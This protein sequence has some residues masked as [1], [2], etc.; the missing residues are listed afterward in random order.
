MVRGRTGPGANEIGLS[1]AHI[2]ASIDGSLRRLGLDFVDLYQIHGVDRSTPL[3]QTMDALDD[4][5][6]SGK[7]RYVGFSNLPA[8]MAMKA[9]A[10]AEAR[11]FARFERPKRSRCRF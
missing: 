11:G 5:V 8:W 2:M 7:V 6:R 10:L 3:E 9:N 4:V 1:R